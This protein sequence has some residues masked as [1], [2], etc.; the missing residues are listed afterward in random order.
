ML[1]ELK[2][3][4]PQSFLLEYYERC[5]AGEIVVG[6]EL[7]QCL[8]NLL[9][10]LQDEQYRFDMLE[11]HKRI[12]FI[13][14]QCKH[15]ISPFAGKPF[16][17]EL[18]EK[19]L[20][21]ATYGFQIFDDELQR[22]IRRFTEIL[23]LIGRKNGKSSLCAALG[24]CEFFCGPVGTNILCS[25]N[26]YEQS[27]IVFDEINNMREESRSLDRVSRKNIKGIFMGNP[28]QKKKKGKF[29]YQNKAKIK[30]LSAKTGAKEGKN[31]DFA[32][33]DE[34]HEMADDSLVM[35][36]KQS[37]S[38]K[39][40]PLLFEI[41]T[42]GFTDDGYLD[43]RLAYARMVLKGEKQNRRLLPWLY[44]QDSEAEVWQNRSSWPKSNPNLGVSKKWSYLDGLVEEA[45]T[46]TTVR[47]F[48]LSK[49]FNIKQNAAAAWLT[50]AD[51]VNTAEFD[52]S[53]LTGKKYIGALD[54]AETTD[55]CSAKAIVLDKD[56]GKMYSMGMYFI[57]EIKADAVLEDD[58]QNLNPEKKNYRE[59]AKQ[60]K[61][62]ICP[63]SEVDPLAVAQWFYG[64][65]Q[66]YGMIPFKIGYDNWH[67]K[68][69]KRLVGEYF[70][71]EVLEQIR[72][73]YASLSGPMRI[74]ESDLKSKKLVYGNN[75]IDR[76][77]LKNVSVKLDN[78]GRIMPVKLQGQ[79]K[80][81]I[82]GALGFIIAYAAYSRYKSEYMS[83]V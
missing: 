10:D 73:D 24:N 32:I 65:Y 57:P 53:I 21:E 59:W 2:E 31:I 78:I 69:F 19:A 38:T 35:P 40:E 3:R 37:M 1:D 70:G 54:F 12:K 55:L 16:L 11:P 22:W 28:K 44:T 49:D 18:W 74:V 71:E 25:S 13:E 6:R 17:L 34:V 8:E 60:G 63:G 82:D 76:W 45:K 66:Q 81:R 20:I 15:S 67:A 75:P 14:T 48:M 79:S 47:A 52:P 5:S 64:L 72:M 77:C 61:V 62:T 68:D 50:E 56:C 27:A 26:D 9:E 58:N 33:V 83:M 23:L 29:S 42:E 43:K 4:Y 51:A 36:I 80:N 7:M 30:K 39:D 41:T 46:E